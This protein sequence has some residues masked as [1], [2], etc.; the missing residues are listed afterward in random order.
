MMEE[1][2][3]DTLK[4]AL[5]KLPGYT[6]APVAWLAICERLEEAPLQHAITQL[7][8]HE[9][10]EKL[11][12]LI[13]RKAPGRKRIFHW[14]YA[15]AVLLAGFIGIWIWRV[16]RQPAVF[17]SQIEIDQ[18]LQAHDVLDTDVQ[19]EKLKA[20]CETE[21]P[22]CNTGEYKQLSAEFENLHAASAQL[23]EV[24]GQYNTEPELVKQL[25]SI[26]KQKAAILN[27]MAKMI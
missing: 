6:P 26:E 15:A 25:N 9:P 16:N 4:K 10:D 12:E 3:H 17:Y 5:A 18:R 20:Y 21:T 7:P 1:T 19:Y 11:W 27:E 14:P 23:Q 2:N 13:E 24:I 22:V 8:G